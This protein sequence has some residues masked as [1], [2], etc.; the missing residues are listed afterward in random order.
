MKNIT[1]TLVLSLVLSLALVGTAMAKG[2]GGGHGGN[3]A[4]SNMSQGAWNLTDAQRATYETIMKE[5]DAKLMPLRNDLIAKNNQLS[6]LSNDPKADPTA[7]GQLIKDMNSTREKMRAER[8]TLSQR[9]EKELGIKTNFGDVGFHGGGMGRGGMGKGGMN[10]GGMNHGGMGMGGGMNHGG[11]G[12]GG[13]MKD[14]CPMMGNMGNTDNTDN[15]TAP[16]TPAPAT[17]AK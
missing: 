13:M 10:H 6:T 17:K 16:A 3:G 5:A 2:H 7:L 8:E 4:H 12:M 9:L 15:T 1:K 11:M 14:G